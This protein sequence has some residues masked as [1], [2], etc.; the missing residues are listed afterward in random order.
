MMA[1]F[2]DPRG[3]AF[4]ARLVIIMP[5]PGIANEPNSYSWSELLTS[6]VDAVPGLR[7]ED[8]RLDRRKLREGGG[9]GGGYTEWKVAYCSVGGMMPL[10]TTTPAEVPGHRAVYFS[11]VDINAAMAKVKEL[12]GAVP[13]GPMEVEPGTFAMVADPQ[14]AVFHVIQLSPQGCRGLITRVR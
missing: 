5:G 13:M 8:L 3:A 12:G 1:V 6:D 2:A 14:G 4:S 11:V 7:R 9:A 10:P